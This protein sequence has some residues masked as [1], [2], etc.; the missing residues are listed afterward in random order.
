MRK[1]SNIMM[2]GKAVLHKG[3]DSPFV[4]QEGE[5]F[6]ISRQSSHE[7]GKVVGPAHRPS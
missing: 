4:Q 3:L 7:G 6:R 1:Y 5:V 2:K